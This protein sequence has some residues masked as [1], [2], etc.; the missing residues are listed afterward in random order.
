MI[1]ASMVDLRAPHTA[2]PA[3][4]K[5]RIEAERTGVP[6]LLY[7][8]GDDRQSIFSLATSTRHTIGRATANTCALPWDTE[9]SRV[10]AELT[11][12]GSEWTIADEGLSRNGTFVNGQR[13]HGRRR[14]RDGDVIEL[15]RT[16]ILFRSP[17][18]AAL[19]ETDGP[20]EE[21]AAPLLTPAQRRVLIALCRPLKD[22][23]APVAPASNKEIAAELVVGV[24]AVKAN[25]RALFT[26]F[27]VENVPQNRKRAR[28]VELAFR[29]GAVSLRDL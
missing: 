9:T 28:L 20:S 6:F 11:L 2:T 17:L 3:E 8:D 23:G 26:S 1:D 22:A 25:L 18:M 24:D 21:Y 7:R 27:G 16:Q 15:G 29:T 14:L 13:V 5:A 4:L 10:H 19:E 12:M